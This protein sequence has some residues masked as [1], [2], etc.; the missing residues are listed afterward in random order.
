MARKRRLLGFDALNLVR[1]IA[2]QVSRNA[3]GSKSDG[4][5]KGEKKRGKR[6]SRKRSDG[7]NV[8]RE[9]ERDPTERF[10]IIAP[11]N[12]PTT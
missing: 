5:K 4:K 7:K 10:T 12:V 6:E 8:A 11:P 2:F 1:S 3:D 9:L